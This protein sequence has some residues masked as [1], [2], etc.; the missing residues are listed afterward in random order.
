M[1]GREWT[2]L[3]LFLVLSYN[4]VNASLKKGVCVGPKFY[5]CNDLSVL[6]N[7]VWWCVYILMV[8]FFYKNNK[9]NNIFL[10]HRVVTFN[11]ISLAL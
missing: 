8:L 10:A 11:N 1:D 5:K 9:G 7:I 3:V 6:N 2:F 4:A